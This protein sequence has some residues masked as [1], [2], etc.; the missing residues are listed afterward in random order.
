MATV[1]CGNK[2]KHG[3]HNW[4]HPLFGTTARCPGTS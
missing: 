4:V 2:K 3:A 1:H